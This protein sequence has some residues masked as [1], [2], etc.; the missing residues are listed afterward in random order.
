MNRIQAGFLFPEKIVFYQNVSITLL[1]LKRALTGTLWV[2]RLTTRQ[3]KRF[4]WYFYCR[5]QSD[6]QSV[7]LTPAENGVLE[8]IYI[9]SMQ[10][11]N[12][13]GMDVVP[14]PVV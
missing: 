8:T 12:G 5:S 2:F 7:N 4:A 11:L 3:T 10:P 6:Q 9:R 1:N 13:M 14:P